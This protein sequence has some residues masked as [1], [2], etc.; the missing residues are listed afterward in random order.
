MDDYY[1]TLGVERNATQ[2]D[3]KKAY[4]RLA[5][6]YHP[7]KEGGD[8]EKFKQVNSAYQVL[9]NDKRRSQYDQ[10]GQTFE[11]AEG[12]GPFPGGFNVNMEDFSNLGSI[13]DQFFSGSRAESS[14]RTPRGSDVNIDTTI[15]FI[16]SSQGITKDINLRLNQT[17][18]H[19]RGNKAEPGTPINDYMFD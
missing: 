2:E 4:R 1:T 15:S 13:F 14:P 6:Q 18:N 16:E 12:A 17:C 3:I 9:G 8:E 11:G 10:F 7:D 5:H 19:C